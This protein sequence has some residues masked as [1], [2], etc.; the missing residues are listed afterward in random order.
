MD[1]KDLL[2]Q[3]VQTD[4]L[5]C[6]DST[7]AEVENKQKK[8]DVLHISIDRKGRKG[9]TATIVYG[10][11]C[12]DTEVADIASKLKTGLGTGGSARGGEILIQ[13]EV[14]EK[15]RNMLVKM[16]YKVS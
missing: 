4:E 11:T 15:V 6:E 2:N 8:K 1:W 3:K 16:G 10:F 9:K 5:P 13:G 7:P 12:P 14:A